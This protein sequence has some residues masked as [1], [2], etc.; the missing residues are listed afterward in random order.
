MRGLDKFF[1][2]SGALVIVTTCLI[3]QL[4]TDGDGENV[5]S[6]KSVFPQAERFLPKRDPLPHHQ[7]LVKNWKTGGYEIVGYCFDTAQ[8]APQVTGY[9]GGFLSSGLLK[10]D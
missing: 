2:I 8:I 1:L 10:Q 4:S 6:L 7:A 5:A 3:R 9:G